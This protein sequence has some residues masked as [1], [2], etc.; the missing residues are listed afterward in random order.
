[1]KRTV[2]YAAKSTEDKHG[3]IP[4]QLADGRK[5]AAEN[6][7]E[8][9]AE[10]T[11][12][13]M[14]AYHGD[15]GPGLAAALADCERLAAEHGTC[16]LIVQHS[17]RLARGDAKQAR[18]LIEIVV[19]ALK[20][21]VELLSVQDREIL[22]GG[23]YALV[24]G[25]IGGMRNN[26]DSKRKGLAV[27]DGIRRSVAER[28][29]YAGG[30]R[31]YGY[32]YDPWIDAEGKRQSRLAIHQAEAAIV[33]KM[34]SEYV[35][36]RAQNAIARDLEME[37]VPTLTPTGSWYAT[38]IAGILKNPLYV[39]MVTLHGEQFPAIGPDGKPTHD[40][41]IDRDTWDAACQLR[42]A[43]GAQGRPRG[44]RTAGRHLLTEGLLRCTC[45]AAMSPVTKKDKRAA[46]RTGY[47]SYHCLKRLHYGPDACSQ[48]PINRELIDESVYRY[49]ERVA[50][51]EDATRRAVK[52]QAARQLSESQARR[53]EAET[54][55]ARAEAALAR[56]EGDYI[57]GRIDAGK[58]NRLEDRLRDEMDAAR[59]QAD[60]HQRRQQ[61]I[62]AAI[63]AFDV[64]KAIAEE[65]TALRRIVAG[66]I[67]DGS[68][69]DLA[70]LRA[71]LK[72]LFA[73]FELQEAGA[74]AF[75]RGGLD[76]DRWIENDPE[77]GKLLNVDRYSLQPVLRR[78]A[79]DIS[80]G[81]RF[82]EGFPA[83]QRAPL[84]LHSNL[85]NFLA[86]W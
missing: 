42:E 26:Q 81:A 85:C 65:L 47:E 78:E 54:E 36:G 66:Q 38:T 43:R 76:G 3:S 46:N 39:G 44:R 61:E 59:A 41:I 6:G 57:A 17:D 74:F 52:E 30:R 25:A 33:R 77:V 37:G 4:D 45:G 82:E 18:H 67:Q 10:F 53:Q 60:Q 72:R 1:M 21:D 75:P 79:V 51:D 8:V 23:D 86:V 34:F 58:W 70:A 56:I 15:R 80:L 83:V 5:L 71:T 68:G 14:S 19:W 29:K 84:V 24:M 69:G 9:V 35:A 20:H 16:T 48:A 50:L 7:Y 11:D 31:P 13:A 49:F 40:P 28:G 73:G 55:L 2:L 64:E 63:A 27:K 32:R 12:E 62:E 22:S